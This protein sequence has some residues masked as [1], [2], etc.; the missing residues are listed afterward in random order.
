MSWVGRGRFV[1]V[2]DSSSTFLAFVCEHLL[3]VGDGHVRK[4]CSN[5][6]CNIKTQVNVAIPYALS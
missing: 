3:D 2:G 1:F 6:R 4:Q 5:I